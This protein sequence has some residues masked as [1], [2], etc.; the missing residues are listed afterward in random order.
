MQTKCPHCQTVFKVSDEHLKVADGYVRCGICKEVFNALEK[1]PQLDLTEAAET[2]TEP[3][4]ADLSTP[5]DE[6]ITSNTKDEIEADDSNDAQADLFAEIA[7]KDKPETDA[8]EI[9][10]AEAIEPEI[11]EAKTAVAEPVSPITET[12]TVSF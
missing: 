5:V 6:T 8:A 4:G 11:V 12:S 7:D 3:D 9:I 1:V 10:E 2:V